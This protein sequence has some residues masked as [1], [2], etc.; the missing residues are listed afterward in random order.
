MKNLEILIAK[1][2]KTFGNGTFGF[3][4][5]LE[6]VDIPRIT[7]GSLFLD[8][9]LGQNEKTGDSGWPLGRIVEMYG[10]ESAGKSLIALTTIAHA[11]TDGMVC[12]YFDCEGSFSKVFA[13]KLGV[14]TNQLLLSR[15]SAGEKELGQIA[16]FDQIELRY[17]DV[18][19]GSLN[20]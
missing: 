15:E 6:F 14:D 2:N 10:P 13:T 4:K 11:Q 7:S 5:T 17:L 20:I 8:W 16:G 9:A 1:I 19:M 3:A 18:G 12:A